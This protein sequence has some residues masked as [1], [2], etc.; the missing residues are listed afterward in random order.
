MT[1]MQRS[2]G[3][4]IAMDINATSFEDGDGAS[5]RFQIDTKG[6]QDTPPVAG[7]ATRG[8]NDDLKVEL[9]QAGRED[10]RHSATTSCFRP[11]TSSA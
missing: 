5:M 6:V 10:D 2:E 7:T 1:E 8:A 4:P 9:T 3:D 11:S